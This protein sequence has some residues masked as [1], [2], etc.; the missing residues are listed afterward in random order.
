M[1]K[2]AEGF[3]RTKGGGAYLQFDGRTKEE[4]GSIPK[5]GGKVCVPGW[6]KLRGRR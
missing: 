6:G 3:Y 1:G 2:Q 4:G 5:K